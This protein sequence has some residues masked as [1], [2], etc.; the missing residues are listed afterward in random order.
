MSRRRAHSSRKINYF[1]IRCGACD[2]W[3]PLPIMAR[4]R[5]RSIFDPSGG[6]VRIPLRLPMQPPPPSFCQI[7]VILQILGSD[8]P[9]L[10]KMFGRLATY[11]ALL[12]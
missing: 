9:G 6:T 3:A 2:S 7:Q 10:G 5:F 12:V 11:V 8:P 1:E 4:L